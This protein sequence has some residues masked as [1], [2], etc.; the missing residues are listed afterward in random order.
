MLTPLLPLLRSPAA[1]LF[2]AAR[3]TPPA[4][5]PPLQPPELK[6]GNL[7]YFLV[8]I[9]HVSVPVVVALASSLPMQQLPL[10]MITT[11]EK[12]NILQYNMQKNLNVVM[13]SILADKQVTKLSVVAV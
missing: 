4:Y 8:A 5:Y 7:A 9:P 11:I 12:L 1:C 10:L 2:L 3:K 6:K 13:A